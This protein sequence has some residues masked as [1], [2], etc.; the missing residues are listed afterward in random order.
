M[1]ELSEIQETARGTR[2]Q[3]LLRWIRVAWG[4]AAGT[5]DYSARRMTPADGI[6]A[7]PVLVEGDKAER[8]FT[9]DLKPGSA[10]GQAEFVLRIDEAADFPVDEIVEGDTPI[11]GARVDSYFAFETAEAL[12]ED[13][14]N[15]LASYA[16]DWAEIVYPHVTLH[17]VEWPLARGA[18]E[19]GAPITDAEYP[20]APT[21][22]Y[23]KIIPHIFGKIEDCPATLVT[24]A[25]SRGWT[26]RWRRGT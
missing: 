21:V 6:E 20:L 14:W 24:G 22:N 9:L 26:D 5:K 1:K 16:V 17:C 13:D 3:K 10:A 18:Q 11:Q 12:V 7:E 19:V 8:N 15:L 25:R 23:G 2:G 4:G